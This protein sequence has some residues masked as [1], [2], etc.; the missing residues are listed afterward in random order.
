MYL[1]KNSYINEYNENK[2]NF[3]KLSNYDKKTWI[4]NI[5]K[6]FNNSVPL[7]NYSKEDIEYSF[8]NLKKKQKYMISTNS[9]NYNIF[10]KHNL[11]S[12]I[13]FIKSNTI[14]QTNKTN[15]KNDF[16]NIH[17]T[18]TDIDYVK[19]YIEINN[20]SNYYQNKQRLE[21]VVDKYIK[22]NYYYKQ[23]YFKLLNE[24][25]NN[26]KY[27][28]GTIIHKLTFTDDY[29]KSIN[30]ILFQE[31]IHKYNKACTIY[32][33]YLFKLFVTI[34][35][36]QNENAIILDLSSGW[37]DR[38]LGVLSIEDKIDKYIGIDPNTAL[39]NGY[40]KMIND[41]SKN[42]NKYELIQKPSEE[43]NYT[44]L[45]HD[46]NIIF[47]SPPFS[48]QED[49]VTDKT[50]NDFEDQST[51]KFKTYEEWEDNFLINVINLSTN[52]LKINGIFIL[53]VG[54]INYKSFFSKMKN[55]KKLKYLGQI[56]L[57]ANNIKDYHI[58]IKTSQP[59]KCINIVNDSLNEKVINIK[60]KL[61]DDIDNP[62][63]NIININVNNKKLNVIQD[64][65]LIAGTK[66]RMVVDVIKKL[67]NN[68]TKNIVY[69]SSY[70]GYGAV[71]TA[72]GAYKLG[73]R[74]SVFLDKTKMGR[75]I[76]ESMET[77]LNSKQ[78]LT[79]MALNAKIF[80]CENYRN[81]RNLEYDYSTL[82]T[83]KDDMWITKEDYIIPDMG[84]NDKHKLMVNILSNK[85]KEA[86]KNT[87]M[88][89]AN[90]IR[91]WLVAGS[92]GIIESLKLCFKNALFFVY[93]TS[94]GK[95]YNN[96]IE[97]I[98]K[99]NNITI[100]NNN[101]NYN[102]QD[103]T[104][105]YYKYYESV[106]NYD[107]MIFTYVKKYGKENDFIWNVACD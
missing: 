88:E 92:G 78:I 27:E 37:G 54:N 8:D 13:E 42:K 20:L 30:P 50:R 58:F 89:N 65:Y 87:I 52:N 11:H 100:L 80:L 62:T 12:L 55:I 67:I 38:L 28:N 82:I 56:H 98:K 102:I 25:F 105:D 103:V 60:N 95:Y 36:P 68:K 1:S 93:I 99:Q 35:K 7:I 86:S 22:T 66:Q 32:K 34:F 101:S 72:Y 83:T 16:L 31:I 2:N 9:K 81:A 26:C 51:N 47:W 73:L 69:A 90:M 70:M 5:Y 21:C 46:I 64:S 97:W 24:Y 43:V 76:P 48:I 33:P 91:I 96:V 107:S 104:N 61:I 106:E 74:C 40:N 75:N 17:L 84:F 3:N 15:K 14:I 45:S 59:N 49:Y 23:N 10:E 53:Y 85:I 6:Y 79:L 71:A 44:K 77:I 4:E 41:F 63:L 57:K 29:A 39:L 19:H 94:G 18:I